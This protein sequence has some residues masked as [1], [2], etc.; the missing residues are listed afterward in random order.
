MRLF[1]PLFFLPTPTPKSSLTTRTHSS[2]SLGIHLFSLWPWF[3]SYPYPLQP[4]TSENLDIL[5]LL[6]FSP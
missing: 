4:S 3:V 6:P 5:N 2:D 1:S